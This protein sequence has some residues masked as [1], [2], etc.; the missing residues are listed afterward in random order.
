MHLKIKF[1][2]KIYILLSVLQIFKKYLL[3]FNPMFLILSCSTISFEG[4]PELKK[5]SKYI[6]LIKENNKISLRHYF[7]ISN[8]WNLRYKEP[9]FLKVGNDII[10]LFLVNRYKLIDYK[11]LQTF[12]SVG[13]D[14]SL[15]AY[16]KLIKARKFVITNSSERVIKTIVFSNLSDSE[17]ILLQNN[18]IN[19]IK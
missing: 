15:K 14:I 8:K 4:I 16:L 6:K 2:K 9:L 3:F 1:Y 13:K 11:Y 17:N 12:F 10:A 7:T 18:M 5:D 19:D